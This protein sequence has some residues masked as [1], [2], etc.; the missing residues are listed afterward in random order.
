MNFSELCIRRPVFATVLS[1]TIVLIG[2]V[3]YQRLSVREYPKI[4]PPVVSVETSYPGASAEII[5]SQVTKVLED[6]LAGIEG[7]DFTTS[8]SR[9]EQ[10]Q[11]SITFNLDRDPSSAAADVRDRV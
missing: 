9:A 11:I 1:L 5:E 3:A 4:D 10:S 6:S 2:L 8:I 7:I